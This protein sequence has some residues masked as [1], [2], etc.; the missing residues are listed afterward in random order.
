MI[1][2]SP[3]RAAHPVGV[4]YNPGAKRN[5][6]V[7]RITTPIGLAANQAGSMATDALI[8]SIHKRGFSNKFV[9]RALSAAF[10]LGENRFE[11]TRGKSNISVSFLLIADPY[12]GKTR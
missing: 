9:F 8:L 3:T 6:R 12:R 7:R 4:C 1:E 5:F 10:L 11:K 2:N